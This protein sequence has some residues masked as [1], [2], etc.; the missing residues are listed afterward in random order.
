MSR[1]DRFLIPDDVQR[2]IRAR[3]RQKGWTVKEINARWSKFRNW[4]KSHM[5]SNRSEQQV[6]AE[7][8]AI[9]EDAGLQKKVKAKGMR[10][11]SLALSHIEP[12]SKGGSGLNF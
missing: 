12:Y 5:K 2:N 9:L 3:L 1:Q 4:F 6:Y 7:L 11:Q 10:R 8:G